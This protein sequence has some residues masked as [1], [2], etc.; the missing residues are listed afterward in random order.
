MRG[1]LKFACLLAL[2]VVAPAV[3]ISTGAANWQVSQTSQS[4]AGYTGQAAGAGSAVNGPALGV[5]GNAA[6]LTGTIPTAFGWA[7][8]FGDGQWVGQL[9]TDGNFPAPAGAQPGTYTYTLTLSNILA[10]VLNFQFA[11]DNAVTFRVLSNG[12]EVYNSGVQVGF[13]LVSPAAVNYSAGTLVLEAV[14]Q[15]GF[16]SG[17]NVRN[18]SGLLVVG[19]TTDN[20][21]PGIPEPSTYAML[22]LGAAGMIVARMRRS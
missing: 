19:A 7:N 21:V 4:F 22:G 6:V 17:V 16:S 2:P 1:F 10:G 12:S 14:V 20:Q 11:T 9:A 5:V 3:T 18:P 13:G 8:A 15:N